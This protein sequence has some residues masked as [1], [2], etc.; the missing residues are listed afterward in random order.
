MFTC[1]LIISIT[2][3]LNFQHSGFVLSLSEFINILCVL[4]FACMYSPLQSEFQDSQGYTEKPC[5]EKQKVYSDEQLQF[6]I[7]VHKFVCS[8]YQSVTS[9]SL[10][11]SKLSLWA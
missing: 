5:L 1:I 9:L 7:Y 11:L 10:N 4:W 6:R 8:I 2:P 3:T